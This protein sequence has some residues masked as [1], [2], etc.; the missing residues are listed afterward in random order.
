[1]TLP[2]AQRELNEAALGLTGNVGGKEHLRLLKAADN[3]RKAVKAAAKRPK[4]GE[5][6]CEACGHPVPRSPIGR[7]RKYHDECYPIRRAGLV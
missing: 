1:M 5:G 4:D 2:E 3:F 6:R 7:P